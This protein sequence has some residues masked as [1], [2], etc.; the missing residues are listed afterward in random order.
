MRITPGYFTL[1]EIQRGGWSH[2]IAP[3]HDIEENMNV[4]RGY[5]PLAEVLQEALDQ[6]QLGK[7]KQCHANGLPFLEQPIMQ[8][9]REAG[10]GGMVYQSRK[11]ILEA[12]NCKD[13]DRAITD[14]LGAINYVAV[15]VL[16][17]RENMS[18]ETV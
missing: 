13:T 17:R 12:M 14:L 2:T 4:E 11:K 3:S 6:A 18:T 10:E 5:E 1:E 15:Q 7:G 8:G 9:A 16:L